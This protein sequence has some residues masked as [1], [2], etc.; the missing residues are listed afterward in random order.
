MS[1]EGAKN[2]VS[3]LESRRRIYG[4]DVARVWTEITKEEAGDVREGGLRKS[5]QA[6]EEA[7]WQRL[8]A[9]R[10]KMSGPAQ[11][12]FDQ[13]TSKVPELRIVGGGGGE[14]SRLTPADSLRPVYLNAA[15]WLT[16]RPN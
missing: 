15:G 7:Q 4:P 6:D 14:S 13:N 10:A 12:A 3:T 5:I 8:G 16:S 11:G 9:L 2:L 1:I